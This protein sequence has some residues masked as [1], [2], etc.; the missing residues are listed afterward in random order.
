MNVNT[1][2][3]GG[4]RD[5]LGARLRWAVVVSLLLNIV[6]W[7][8]ASGFARQTVYHD[9]RPVEITRVVLD[10]GK[11]IEKVVTKKQIEKK[12]AQAHKEIQKRKPEWK[13]PKPREEQKAKPKPTRVA[14]KPPEGAHNRVITAL[15]DKNALPKPDD[16]TALAGGNA[17][18]G[19]PIEQQNAGNAAT[20]PPKPEPPKPEPAKPEP[21]KPEPPKPEPAKPEP[22]KPE[23][24]KP[25]P[26]APEPAKPEPP[27]PEPPKPKGP[28]KEAEAV[29]TIKPE[30]PDDLKKGE[31]RSFVRVKVEID[32]D[33]SFTPILRTSSG[34]MEID[35]RVLDSL[36]RWRWKPA[37]KDGIPVKSTQLF[38]FEFLVE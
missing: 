5:A 15:P 7:R 33:G 16:H 19:K 8:A 28:T 9:P 1:I 30:I 31:Y 27:K 29:N 13:P 34:N 25:E 23:P 24:A 6:L 22:A 14:S 10:K 12:V 3:P 20:N 4:F 11:K 26:P 2:L 36:K 38:K 35:R 32:P 17:A 18:A 21:P 37:L